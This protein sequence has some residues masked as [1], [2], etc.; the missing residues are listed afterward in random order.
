M[1]YMADPAAYDGW[2]AVKDHPCVLA[3]Y[4]LDEP[5]GNGVTPTAT[6][7][8]QRSEYERLRAK[9]PGHPIGTAHYIWDALY[10]Y[11]CSE[12]FT[13]SDVYPIH[14]API[15]HVSLFVDR[16]HQIH[17]DGY[18]VWPYIQC[19]GG[20]EGFD[21]PSP[22]EE[23]LMVYLALAHRA[24]GIM[25]FSYYPSLTETWAE[26]KKLVGEMKQLAPFYC[27]PSQE[28]AL[29]NTNGVIHTRLIKIGDSGL[30][31]AANGDGNAQTT[32]ITI[33]SPAPSTLNLP[34]EGGSIPVTAGQFTASFDP[35]AVHVYQWGPTPQ[36]DLFVP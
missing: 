7:A 34:F 3:W 32:T 27:L 17:G 36:A 13:K 8:V 25:F 5:E 14:R 26:V 4:I 28:P 21:V 20:T 9:D 30:I 29:G 18:P 2:L 6:P 24:K 19:F 22:A 12:D 16:I 10:N 15:T 23:R 33:P 35:L 11:R 31:I 1:P